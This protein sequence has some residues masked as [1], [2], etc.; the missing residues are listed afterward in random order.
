LITNDGRIIHENEEVAQMFADSLFPCDDLE[1]DEDIHKEIRTL[2]NRENEEPDDLPF[3]ENEVTEVINSQN[4]RKSPGEDGITADI[5]KNLHVINPAFLTKLYNKCLKLWCFPSI[6]KSCVVKVVRKAGKSDYRKVDV[7]RPI[8]LLSVFAKILEKI[9]INRISHFLRES[10]LLSEKQYGFTPQKSTEDAL[11]VMKKFINSAFDNKGF[12]I[13]IALDIEGAF[14]HNWWQKIISELNRKKCPRNLF[15]L[16]KSYFTERKAKIWVLNTEVLREI[17]IGC[18]QG[19]AC[20][21]MFWNI[22]YND[23]LEKDLPVN[24]DIISFA[25]D[26]IIQIWAKTIADLESKANSTLEEIVRW[27]KDNKLKFN[28]TKTVCVLYTRN[29]KFSQ[30]RIFLN[31][32][33]LKISQSFKYL[34]IIIDSKLSWRSHVNYITNKANQLIMELIKFAKNQFGLNG[35]SLETIYKGAVLP[36]ISYGVSVWHE[37]IDRKFVINH[38]NTLQRLVALRINKSYKTVSTDASNI[39]ANFMPIDLHLKKISAEYFIKN[40]ISNNITREL[41]AN[42]N[43]NLE[44]IQKRFPNKLMPKF[45]ERLKPKVV[46]ETSDQTIVYT[47]GSKSAQGV[48]A[49]FCVFISENVIKKVKFKLA[50]YCTAFQTELF[51][52]NKALEFINKN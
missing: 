50:N 16:A 41:L 37:A 52:I 42:C 33:Q 49:A 30:P 44:N 32:H 39:L 12:A 28:E 20:G 36:L 24:T 14:N 35:R 17:N 19:S 9:L 22:S 43:I 10:D 46:M 48:G 21:P 15:N 5:I 2:A 25:D 18:P 7:Y 26:T 3:T 13:T 45:E 8:S 11:H 40:G 1:Q 29:L 31:G 6:W 47:G 27:A 51:A 38:L 23:L 34:G 4:H